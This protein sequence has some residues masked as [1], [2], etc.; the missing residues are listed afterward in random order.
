[1]CKMDPREQSGKKEALGVYSRPEGNT[2]TGIL[3]GLD[4]GSGNSMNVKHVDSILP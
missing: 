2:N 1:M 3:L 4:S